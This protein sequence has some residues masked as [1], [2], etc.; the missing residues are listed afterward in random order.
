MIEVH[1]PAYEI[2]ICRLIDQT[3]TS[4]DAEA[5]RLRLLAEVKRGATRLV[6]DLG[7][8]SRID[9]GGISALFRV[10]SAMA[11]RGEV[12]LVGVS[13]AL[14]EVLAVA[15]LDEVFTIAADEAQAIARSGRDVG[16]RV[17]RAG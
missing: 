17:A 11:G 3:I 7:Q 9:A 6:I 1:Y 10:H 13:P 4:P 2:C 5:L 8:V 12:V 14:N 15:H 16:A